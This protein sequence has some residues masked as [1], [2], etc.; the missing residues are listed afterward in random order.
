[1]VFFS[2]LFA[3]LF[4]ILVQEMR[5]RRHYLQVNFFCFTFFAILSAC[6][7][8]N[9]QY[10]IFLRFTRTSF[11]SVICDVTMGFLVTRQKCVYMHV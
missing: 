6:L 1:M 11:K 10:Y 7:L 4:S 9:L 5:R 2:S 8:K 3:I